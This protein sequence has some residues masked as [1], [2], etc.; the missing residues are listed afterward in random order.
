MFMASIDSAWI[1]IG[2]VGIGISLMARY[3]APD[4]NRIP[5]FLL[6][7]VAVLCIGN[8]TA[9]FGAVWWGNGNWELTLSSIF[10]IVPALG[11]MVL[12]DER[13]FLWLVIFGIIHASFIVFT[14]TPEGLTFNANV[15]SG[16]LVF[17]G[18][19]SIYRRF[20]ICIAIFLLIAVAFTE[21]RWA[22]VIYS[23]MIL[24]GC[25]NGRVNWRWLV[26]IVVGSMLLITVTDLTYGGYHSIEP[27]LLGNAATDIKIRL[28]FPDWP[29]LLPH[30]LV[31]HR[32]LHNVP[33][34]M[35]R[36]SGLITGVIW[37]G[38]SVWALSRDRGS[39]WWWLMLGVICLS[40]LDYYTWR[41]HLGAFWFLALGGIARTL[42]NKDQNSIFQTR[43]FPS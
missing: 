19:I 4:K 21:S 30:G 2:G 5:R 7:I 43:V 42:N 16:I 29:D 11:V 9:I 8:L 39:V 35:A 31:E 36:E 32:G 24:A 6:I 13:V 20:P 3:L 34:R 14:G 37:V 25:L 10:W 38:L 41:P 23:A 18:I 26:L 15:S 12:A 22:L 1:L 33:L 40:M 27:K 28:S 17:T